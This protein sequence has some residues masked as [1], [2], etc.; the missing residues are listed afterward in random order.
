M[1]DEQIIK[2]AFCQEAE[3]FSGVAFN[4]PF[5]MNTTIFPANDPRERNAVNE[6]TETPADAPEND[7]MSEEVSSEDTDYADAM[8]DDEE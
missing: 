7:V 5:F 4:K 3:A 2:D 1:Q 6:T 8:A